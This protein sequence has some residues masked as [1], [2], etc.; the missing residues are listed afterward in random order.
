MSSAGLFYTSPQPSF[1]FAYALQETIGGLHS[2][3][4]KPPEK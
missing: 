2:Q 3:L 4:E 1:G